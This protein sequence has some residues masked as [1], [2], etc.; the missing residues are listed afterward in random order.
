[1]KTPM[2]LLASVGAVGF[3]A[4]ASAVPPELIDARSAYDTASKGPAIQYAPGDLHVA[5]ESLATAE[6]S[7]Q[8]GATLTKRVTWPMLPS[9]GRSLPPPKRGPLRPCRSRRTLRVSSKA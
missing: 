1:M 4:C 5:Q 6:A 7:F 8:K 2:R 9:A 3:L